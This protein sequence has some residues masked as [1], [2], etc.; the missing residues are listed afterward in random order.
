MQSN[1]FKETATKAIQ[2]SADEKI[3]NGEK[4][5]TSVAKKSSFENENSKE[6]LAITEIQS[7]DE[8]EEEL[9]KIG[10]AG[11][12]KVVSNIQSERKDGQTSLNRLDNEEAQSK[13][14]ASPLNIPGVLEE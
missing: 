8:L 2:A 14:I 3:E 4:I 6:V 10:A 13:I 9:E 11:S 1:K 12:L 7:V 5:E